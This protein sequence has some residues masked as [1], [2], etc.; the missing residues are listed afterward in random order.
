M[1]VTYVTAGAWGAGNG[2]T[3][4][5]A[6]T[7]DNN[8]WYVYGLITSIQ[9]SLPEPVQI[10]NIT[11][12]GNTITIHMEDATTYGPFSLPKAV[13]ET[14]V[15]NYDAESP[16][17]PS[18]F[19]ISASLSGR[20]V[21]VNNPEGAIVTIPDETVYNAPTNT[22][23]HFAQ[24]TV[25]GVVLLVPD[26]TNGVIVNGMAGKDTS[27]EQLGSVITLKKVGTDEW[28]LFGQ[29]GDLASAGSGS[30]SP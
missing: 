11:Q 27:T 14:I 18:V 16:A 30:G 13:A 21:R 7:V 6:A 2:G 23:I 3:P 25:G 22:E 1:A 9:A 5:T 15:V 4:L 12:S 28:D 29:L 20:Y 19:T 24:R 17:G 8:F 10:S 26:A